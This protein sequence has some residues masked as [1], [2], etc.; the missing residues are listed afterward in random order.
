MLDFAV[1]EVT[2]KCNL[3]CK[4]CYGGG[5]NKFLSTEDKKIVLKNLKDVGCRRVTLSGG[6]PFL[7]GM[8]LFELAKQFKSNNIEVGVV[9]N[10]TLITMYA[11]EMY[12]VFDYIQ[13]SLD[14]PKTIHEKI[15]GLGTFDKAIK[16]AK[17]LRDSGH[18]VAF[19]ITINNVNQY[20]FTETFNIAKNMG[21]KLSVE[22]TSRIGNASKMGN[23]DYG[24]YKKILKIIVDEKL[25]SSDPLVNATACKMASI[26][27]PRDIIKGCSAGK[28][29]IAISSNLDV[30]P[31]V[32]LRIPVLGNLRNETLSKILK[33]QHCKNIS[34]R[35]K[36]KGKCGKC[37]LKYICGGCRADAWIEYN[38][39]LEEDIGCLYNFS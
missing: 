20:S 1:L 31:C 21:I 5:G 19:Q 2:D 36:L 38:D 16:S 3:R 29:G 39:Y 28:C 18:N 11:P 34:N 14:G 24:N 22:R 23:I 25:L 8:D 35:D 27:P 15:R 30:Y 26:F 17:Y 13:I 6:E 37:K 4:H 32:R 10:G 12:S 7:S 33:T 9:T